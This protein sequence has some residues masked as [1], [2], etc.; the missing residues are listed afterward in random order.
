MSMKSRKPWEAYIAIDIPHKSTT[1]ISTGTNSDS[2][3]LYQSLKIDRVEKARLMANSC[4]CMVSE[5]LDDILNRIGC[6]GEYREFIGE[7]EA[8][9]AVLAKSL[10]KTLRLKKGD[11][12]AAL[13]PFLRHIVDKANGIWRHKNPTV[14]RP[15]KYYVDDTHKR[16]VYDTKLRPDIIISTDICPN[17][18]TAELIMKFKQS[19]DKG[20]AATGQN[21]PNIYARL[22]KYACHMWAKQ[23]TRRFV[24]VLLVH[25][26]YVTLVLFA[27]HK[28]YRTKIGSALAGN[29]SNKTVIRL[30]LF[31]LSSEKTNLGIIL[32]HDLGDTKAVSFSPS[33][34]GL[35]CQRLGVKIVRKAQRYQQQQSTSP[36][37]DNHPTTSQ[38]EI[39]VVV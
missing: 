34:P 22:R 10:P 13:M 39:D 31:L 26:L 5:S 11:Q 1:T 38:F 19:E 32:P 15:R 3:E 23:P 17:F 14:R 18:G 9:V 4:A 2:S 28:V 25:D 7:H 16:F 35:F 30:L 12:Q 20:A 21:T 37:P 29:P 33:F 24:P 27:R 8:D 6:S 36:C